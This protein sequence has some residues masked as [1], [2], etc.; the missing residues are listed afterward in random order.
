MHIVKRLRGNLTKGKS[1][2]GYV[3]GIDPSSCFCLSWSPALTVRY[4]TARKGVSVCH[5]GSSAGNKKG[6]SSH[7]PACVGS[8][9]WAFSA[10]RP[11]QR[12]IDFLW[13]K[14]RLSGPPGHPQGPGDSAQRTG[15]MSLPS[16]GAAGSQPHKHRTGSHSPR[17]KELRVGREADQ[18]TVCEQRSEY[19]V[20]V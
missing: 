1:D 11:F 12:S 16:S 2:D 15:S 19:R 7:C 8:C 13:F 9:S 6:V 20:H 3:I 18:E 14:V 17:L 10:R 4:F 5:G